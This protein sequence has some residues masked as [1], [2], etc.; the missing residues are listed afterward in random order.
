M[1]ITPEEKLFLLAMKLLEMKYRFD[2]GRKLFYWI[3]K[4]VV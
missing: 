2:D 4:L 1:T 3:T